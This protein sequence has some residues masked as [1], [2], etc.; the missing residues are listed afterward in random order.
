MQNEFTVAELEAYL[1]EALD[2]ERMAAIEQ[3]LRQHPELLE[4]LSEI[5]ARRDCGMHSLAEV[6]RRHQIGVPSREELGSFLLG[7]LP[8]AH[9][10]YLRFRTE[11]LKCRF[12]IANLE[13][14]RAKQS[15]S[16]KSAVARRK[17]YFQSSVGRLKD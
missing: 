14:L 3:E 8:E 11:V 10:E 15:A 5:N 16:D 4:R 17:K 1:D 2:A 12:T 9:A 6:W 7:V 13:D